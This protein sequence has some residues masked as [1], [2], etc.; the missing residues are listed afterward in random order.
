MAF[1]RPAG[2]LDM[3]FGLVQLGIAAAHLGDLSHAYECIEYLVNSYWSPAMVSMHNVKDV[4][5]LDISGGLPALIITMLVQSAIREKEDEPWVIR[6]L[7]CLPSQWPNGTLK[8]VRCRG[9]FE[10]DVTWKAG[11]LEFLKV[12]SLRG[13]VCRLVYHQ[14]KRERK[15]DKGESCI[16]RDGLTMISSK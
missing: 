6:I 4:F 5:N 10:I 16:L 15:L 2:G 1:R 14:K 11:A 8:G 9:G 7:P 12:T 3:A 13:G